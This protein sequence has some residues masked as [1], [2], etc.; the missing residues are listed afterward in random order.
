MID[1]LLFIALAQAPPPSPEPTPGKDRRDK[2][3]TEVLLRPS[4]DSFPSPND[5]LVKD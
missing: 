5:P 2:A 4:T 3:S 1:V